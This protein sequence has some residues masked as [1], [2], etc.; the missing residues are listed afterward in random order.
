MDHFDQHNF[1]PL[2]SVEGRL[3]EAGAQRPGAS[4]CETVDT[5]FSLLEIFS[6]NSCWDAEIAAAVL[7]MWS[8][9]SWHVCLWVCFQC[10][11]ASQH[12]RN[13]YWSAGNELKV[14]PSLPY[15]TI[16]HHWFVP[17]VPNYPHEHKAADVP[18]AS[19]LSCAA[20]RL[21]EIVSVCRLN[22]KRQKAEMDV[23]L[24]SGSWT[25]FGSSQRWIN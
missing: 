13:V 7:L 11:Q 6:T 23:S 16:R 14:D 17:V 12:H 21:S 2:S 4:P 19:L 1:G 8:Y 22:L 9:T 24:D 10:V 18:T 3:W 25:S 5:K 20:I 15:V